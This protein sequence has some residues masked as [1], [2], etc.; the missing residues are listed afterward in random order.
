MGTLSL[1]DPQNG[2]T[3][4]ATLIANNN[5]AIKTVVNGGIDPTN[6]SSSTRL[7]GYEVVYTEVT[8]DTTVSTSTA[9]DLATFAAATFEATKYYA[10]VCIPHLKMSTTST[11]TTFALQ[12]GTTAVGS[13]VVVPVAV[14]A[15]NQ[16]VTFRLPFTPTAAS[17][18]YK[19][20]WQSGGATTSTISATS[21]AQASFAITKA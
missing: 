4:D 18:T 2:T 1:T 10:T 12:E 19:W 20:T 3:A 7:P 9:S 17:H 6:L 15:R 14:A 5:A 8:S 13:S 11:S 16:V 21:L